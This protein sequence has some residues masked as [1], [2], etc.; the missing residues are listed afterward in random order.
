[1]LRHKQ[2]CSACA[3]VRR[4]L[5]W[6]YSSRLRSRTENNCKPEWYPQ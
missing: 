2:Y 6:Q 3:A 4:L 1:M 5:D